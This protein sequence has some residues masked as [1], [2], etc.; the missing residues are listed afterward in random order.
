MQSSPGAPPRAGADAAL[1][2]ACLSM[3][4]ASRR[5][6]TP[7]VAVSCRRVGPRAA[8]AGLV[9]VA[10]PLDGALASLAT[11]RDALALGLAAGVALAALAS[12][13]LAQRALRPARRIAEAAESIRSGN[14]GERIGYRG[15]HDELGALAAVLDAC[16]AELEQAVDR[17]R[18]FVADASHELKTPVAAVRAHAE[19][20]RGWAA[21]DPGARSAAL[22]SL[23][24]AARRMGRLVGDLLHLSELDRSPSLAR[25]PVELDRLVLAV[26]AEAGALRPEVPI[27]VA[28]LDDAVVRGDAV[29]L[30]QVLLNVLENALRVSPSGSEVTI[31]VQREA[32]SASIAVRDRGPGVA[33]EVLERMF[34][35]FFRLPGKGGGA[36]L[37]LAIAREIARAHG[38]ELTATNAPDGGACLRFT[39]PCPSSSDPHPHVTDLLAAAPTVPGTDQ[40]PSGGT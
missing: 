24:Q 2:G 20:L 17:Q 8:P 23:D 7:P 13:A 38:G 18:R 26:I 22:A 10:A 28:R 16:F 34:D 25:L 30:Q 5:R 39:L 6:A 29:R 15:G 32:T 4:E 36:G 37:G 40:P 33:P 19:L 9:V 31:G 27:R 12:L 14:L 35:R 11:L 21:A 3:G 1:R